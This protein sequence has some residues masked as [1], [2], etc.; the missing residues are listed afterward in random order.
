M[1]IGL[2]SSGFF[3]SFMIVPNMTE[4]MAA[5]EEAYPRCAGTEH[6][7]S[8]LSGMLNALYGIG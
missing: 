7:N 2:A 3:I 5:M 8:M 1:L 4:M 6:T